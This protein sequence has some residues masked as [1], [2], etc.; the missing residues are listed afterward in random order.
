ML[1]LILRCRAASRAP[2]NSY[3][4]GPNEKMKKALILGDYALATWHPLRGVDD[5]LVRILDQYKVE[6]CE[7]YPTLTLEKLKEYDFVVNYI[8]NWS[9]RGNSNCA[10][11]L[12]AYVADGGSMM[13]IH[14][15]IIIKNHPELEQLMCGAFLNHPKHEVLKYTIA[16]SHP[17]TKTVMPFEIDEEPYM[18]KMS[19]LVEPEIV[20]NYEYKGEQYPAVWLRS[21][22]KGKMIYITPGHNAETFKHKGMETLIRQSALWCCGELDFA[23]D[24]PFDSN[25]GTR[26]NK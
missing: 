10:G 18:F 21:F 16:K 4:K 19:A 12:I 14:N 23:H 11:A 15:G 22:G 2:A 20:M 8:D 5:E 13:A 1:L 6:I 9:K 17:L 3:G 7:D 25:L 24:N 26:G